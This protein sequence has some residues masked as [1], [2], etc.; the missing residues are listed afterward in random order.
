MDSSL[1]YDFLRFPCE[2]GAAA[3]DLNYTSLEF[4]RFDGRWHPAP[5]FRQQLSLCTNPTI[6]ACP[7]DQSWPPT[8]Q[9][10]PYGALYVLPTLPPSKSILGKG[11]ANQ[12]AIRKVGS[13]HRLQTFPVRS[14]IT[15]I[16][17]F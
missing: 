11:L 6:A 14:I 9:C 8:R 7:K 15:L 4:P 3:Q 12:D 16:P 17:I 1:V 13:V 5:T 10:P 2:N